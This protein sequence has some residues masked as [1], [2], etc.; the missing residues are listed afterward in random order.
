MLLSYFKLTNAALFYWQVLICFIAI[1]DILDVAYFLDHPVTATVV[2]AADDYRDDRLFYQY[3]IVL[4]AL[5]KVLIMNSC[6]KPVFLKY[7][8]FHPAL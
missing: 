5:Q 8:L 4:L 1:I 6:N 7:I 2:I 3:F